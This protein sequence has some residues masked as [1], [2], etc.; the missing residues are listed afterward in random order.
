MAAI[1]TYH[2]GDRWHVRRE[3]DYGGDPQDV[4]G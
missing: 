4:P 1:E 2:E 3:G